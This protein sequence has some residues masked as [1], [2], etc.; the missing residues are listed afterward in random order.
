MPPKGY[1]THKIECLNCGKEIE[2]PNNKKYRLRKFC[3]LYCSNE[4]RQI[5]ETFTFTC[6][7]CEFAEERKRTVFNLSKR[8][9]VL[10][11]YNRTS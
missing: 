5:K 7:F 1:K 3:S 9:G 2:L 4:Y 8:L 10:N 6:A 11:G